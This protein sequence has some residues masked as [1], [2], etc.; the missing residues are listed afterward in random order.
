[1]SDDK[2]G[3]LDMLYDFSFEYNSANVLSYMQDGLDVSIDGVSYPDAVIIPLITHTQRL[4][5]DSAG[6]DSQSGNLHNAS[7]TVQGVKY[8][9]LKP[10]VRVYALI[11][12]I[13]K[14]TI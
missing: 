6:P 3:G 11:K 5:Y 13:E 1:M 12:A 7:G 2:L 4:Y 14:N 8:E 9:Q 10:A